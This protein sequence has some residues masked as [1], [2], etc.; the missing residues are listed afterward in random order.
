[1]SLICI[2]D[3][4]SKLVKSASSFSGILLILQIKSISLLTAFKTHPLFK[5]GDLSSLIKIIGTD[6]F[7]FD[8]SFTLKKSIWIGLSFK[9]SVCISFG[10]TFI[11]FLFNFRLKIVEK[12][13]VLDNSLT[14]FG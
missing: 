4:S 13:L 12:K 14:I 9:G 7:I 11:F 5:P 8:S 1:M 6:I 2:T 10:K 3:P